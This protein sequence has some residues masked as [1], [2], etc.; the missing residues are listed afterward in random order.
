MIELGDFMKSV[1]IICEYNPFHNGHLYHLEKVKELFPDYPIILVMSGCFTERGEVSLISKWDRT[2]IALS[3]GVSLV[4]ELPFPFA[5]SSADFFAKGA[6]SILKALKVEVIV[7]GSESNDSKKL[8]DLAHIQLEDKNYQ[9]EVK[10]LLKEGYNYPTATSQAL[11]KRTGEN[12]SSP[13]D[14][15]GLSYTKEIIRQ[16]ANIKIITIQRTDNYHTSIT[17]ATGIRNLLLEGKE[18]KEYVPDLAY[19]YYKKDL[20]FT[21]DY[22]PFLKYQIITNLNNLNKFQGMEEGIENRIKKE[23]D[24]STTYEELINRV[25][26][27]RYTY[28][29]LNRLFTYILCHFTKEEAKKYRE[30]SYLR[31]L[32]F[33]KLGQKYLAGIKKDLTLPTINRY[34]T[35]RYPMLD[36]E[37]RVQHIYNLTEQ[38]E[39]GKEKEDY[40]HPPIQ[41]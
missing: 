18:I 6:I 26:T 28:Q 16:N 13:N 12:L 34:R 5:C 31:I 3:Y 39:K 40:L 8:I 27:K 30:V 35:G 10:A 37:N 36:L 9:E 33:S 17:S 11:E 32:G 24:N 41:F 20:H 14:I 25:K 22:F 38:K 23:I 19:P 29:R 1:G 4:V 15:L 2:K 21:K 7:F